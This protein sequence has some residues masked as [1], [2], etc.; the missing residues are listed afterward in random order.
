[1][2]SSNVKNI[3]IHSDIKDFQL[4]T[5]ALEKL[6][7]D[8]VSIKLSNS[9]KFNYNYEDI[10][11]VYLTRD[12][13]ELYNQILFEKDRIHNHTLYVINE[14]D[15]HI[16]I[17]LSRQGFENIFALPYD[18]EKFLNHIRNQL[19]DYNLDRKSKFSF[20]DQRE[21]VF[22]SIM[23]NSKEAIKML[24]SA[25][26][27]AHTRTNILILGETGTGKGL[28]AKAI[29]DYGNPNDEPFVDVVC[30]A[31][32]ENLLE[33]ELF[34][35]QKGAF[36]G[37]KT[38]KPGL[39]EI[40]DGGTI[41]LDEVGDLSL[42]IQA[43]LLRVVEKKVIRRVGGVKDIPV[44]VKIISAT[45]RD[46]EELVKL[47]LFRSDLYYRLNI[48]TLKIPPLRERGD[49]ILHLTEHFVIDFSKKMKIPIH[50][51]EKDLLQ[52]LIKYPWPGNIR[53]LR[54]AIERAVILSENNI[55]KLKYFKSNLEKSS[56]TDIQSALADFVPSDVIR[57]DI[58]YETTELK[59]VNKLYAKKVLEKLEGNK[60]KTAK[61]LGVT[62]PTLDKLLL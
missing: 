47:K 16:G 49:D 36:T 62:R 38:D 17:N 29:H 42:E 18:K 5:S 35:Y 8:N 11:I 14:F 1:M 3:W 44:N 12:N 7:V 54:N 20:L 10:N 31:I 56:T 4:V 53:E 60:S 23:G 9:H 2:I 59:T 19:K 40:A 30:T 51:I 28:L 43:K 50:Q 13:S 15:A 57:M 26:K 21:Y 22:N 37:A 52:F 27:V 6:E 32:P 48:V 46:L 45:N 39:F 55:L 61:T 33:S 24:E 34:G 58:K 25:K 41:F